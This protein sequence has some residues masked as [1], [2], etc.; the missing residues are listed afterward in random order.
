MC[1]VPL[2]SS[3]G[4]PSGTHL[5]LRNLK[6]YYSLFLHRSH[7]ASLLPKKPITSSL[8]TLILNR[9]N[10]RKNQKQKIE[11]ELPKRRRK[12]R[13]KSHLCRESTKRYLILRRLWGEGWWWCYWP[14][15]W[16]WWWW[17]HLR[18]GVAEDRLVTT[19]QLIH[20]FIESNGDTTL[21]LLSVAADFTPRFG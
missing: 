18:Q 1:P 5:G 20:V 13:K 4:E 16:H 8:S 10:Q 3:R 9:R 2:A 6:F 17:W 15:W 12:E 19:T 7:L 14:Q 11:M 21:P